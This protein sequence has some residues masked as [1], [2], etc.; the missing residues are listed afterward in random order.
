[1]NQ[2]D[3]LNLN[4]DFEIVR[5]NDQY[6]KFRNYS[7]TEFTFEVEK[8]K[9]ICECFEITPFVAFLSAFTS[10][11]HE[12]SGTNQL[13]VNVP[14]ANRSFKNNII[15]S[16]LNYLLINDT[17][18]ASER[19]DTISTIPG[20]NMDRSMN[21]TKFQSI[22]VSVFNR[23]TETTL[24]PRFM[25]K[26]IKNINET[27]NVIRQFEQVSF[28]TLLKLIRIKLKKL[29]S[30]DNEVMNRLHKTVF[31]NF[32]YRLE[33]N[34]ES[35]LRKGE[36]QAPMDCIHEIEIEIDCLKS[37][38]C[39]RIRMKNSKNFRKRILALR[40]RMISFLQQASNDSDIQEIAKDET[41]LGENGQE[42]M[43]KSF[44]HFI[45]NYEG[46]EA[47]DLKL[48]RIWSE[49]LKKKWIENDDDFCLEGGASLLT[50][51]LRHLIESELKIH[52][53]LEEIFTYS[54]FAKLSSLLQK[55][56]ISS[57]HSFQNNNQIYEF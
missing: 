26:Y 34:C 2:F 17:Q 8:I 27:V 9:K 56:F 15:R 11:L 44:K 39:Y 14:F 10:S 36:T 32:C 49:C 53:E 20:E 37:Y 52:I 23:Q 47:I 50:L 6:S 1:M 57:N 46:N 29:K 21:P 5:E 22:K 19:A 16:F 18:I 25:K 28:I 40:Q 43:K 31:F 12:L 55:R 30:P 41:Q 7:E 48:R 35:A 45:N 13:I 51:K 24:L 42:A 33:E 54:I 3:R 38:Y 4:L